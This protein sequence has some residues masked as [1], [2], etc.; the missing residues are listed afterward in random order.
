MFFKKD[1]AGRGLNSPHFHVYVV[2][3]RLL[4]QI[5]VT[6][7]RQENLDGDLRYVQVIKML[8]VSHFVSAMYK[9]LGDVLL[10]DDAYAPSTN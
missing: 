7:F 5:G 4:H 3:S 1:E 10:I 6:G 9:S 2:Y 8:W